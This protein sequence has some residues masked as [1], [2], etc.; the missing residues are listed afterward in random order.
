MR[1]RNGPAEPR[2]PSATAGVPT[3]GE[4][5]AESTDGAQHA[6]AGTENAGEAQQAAGTESTDDMDEA[7]DNR[8]RP[9]RPRPSARNA[10]RRAGTA[11]NVVRARLAGVVWLVALLC[12][13]VLALGAI[14]VALE[15]NPEN[16]IVSLINDLAHKIDGPFADMF[17]FSGDNAA[18]KEI[19]VNWGIGA[20]VYLVIG[21]I[22][23]RIIRP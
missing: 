1:Q 19:L 13:V 7:D 22:L 8:S 9:S 17:T 15:A 4:V 10:A 5:A 14:L 21:R 11:V 20:V 18:K 16:S 3:A 23:E 2:G 12:A 6:T